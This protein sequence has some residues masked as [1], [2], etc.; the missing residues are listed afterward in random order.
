[1]K[2]LSGSLLTLGLAALAAGCGTAAPVAETIGRFAVA[3]QQR[4]WDTLYCLSAGAASA[5]ELGADP[6]TRRSGFADW[7]RSQGLDPRSRA[8]ANARVSGAQASLSAARENAIAAEADASYWTGQ[9]ARALG[10]R[11]G[12]TPS[13]QCSVLSFQVQVSNS[14]H[15]FFTA[16][17]CERGVE[18]PAVMPNRFLP[19][20]ISGVISPVTRCD[21]SRIRSRRKAR[22]AAWCW[23]CF[24]RRR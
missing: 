13:L 15:I 22:P 3:V 2:C 10:V 4:D 18:A 21:G 14:S 1:M 23:R 17:T 16:S 7:A 6:A 20:I 5:T 11:I 24:S 8:E 12:N 19:S 9:L